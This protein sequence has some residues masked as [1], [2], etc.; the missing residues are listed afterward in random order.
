[1]ITARANSKS[2][3]VGHY[4]LLISTG[5]L[6]DELV[7]TLIHYQL[8]RPLD[9][10]EV[11]A[12]QSGIV[13]LQQGIE[14]LQEP[15]TFWPIRQHKLSV[16]KVFELFSVSTKTSSRPKTQALHILRELLD[17]L[18]YLRRGDA[19]DERV[20]WAEQQFNHL[21]SVTLSLVKELR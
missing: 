18:A 21:G 6:A 2:K 10:R 7:A 4:G 15:F 17:V 14:D 19:R 20:Q 9:A 16:E 11:E 1:V 12:L 13:W 8:G 5:T 3:W